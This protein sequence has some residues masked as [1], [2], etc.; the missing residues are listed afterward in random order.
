MLNKKKEF[1]EISQ[2]SQEN[3]CAGVSFL[4]KFFEK[5]TLAQLFSCEI[6]EIPMNTFFTEYPVDEC[7]LIYNKVLNKTAKTGG[8][9]IYV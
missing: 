4:I 7:F 3:A 8:P 2:N 1:L 6:C 9:F 5:E